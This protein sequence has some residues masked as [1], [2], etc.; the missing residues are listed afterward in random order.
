M[1]LQRLYIG[2]VL[3]LVEVNKPGRWSRWPWPSGQDGFAFAAVQL[4]GFRQQFVFSF[5]NLS[6]QVFIQKSLAATDGQAKR[7][8]QTNHVF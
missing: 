4:K 5:P 3:C 7:I 2:L 6:F 1:F 8:S